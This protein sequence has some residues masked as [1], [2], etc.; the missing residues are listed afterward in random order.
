MRK[1]EGCWCQGGPLWPAET[2][3]FTYPPGAGSRVEGLVGRVPLNPTKICARGY[4]VP[5]SR[6]LSTVI[7]VLSAAQASGSPGQ[8]LSDADS[9]TLRAAYI[10]ELHAAVPA[11]I[12]FEA[13]SPSRRW[14]LCF[15]ERGFDVRPVDAS[16]TWGL[17]LTS[18]GFA[19]ALRTVA[20]P[21][22]VCADG[23]RVTYAWDGTL[24]EWYVNDER[25]LEHGYTVHERPPGSAEGSLTFTLAVR[26]ELRPIVDA[27]GRGVRFVND[28]ATRLTYRG[29]TVFDADGRE[30]DAGFELVGG[31]LRLCIDERGA[32]YPLTIDPVVQ[33][34]YLK[35]L[36]PDAGDWGAWTVAASGD[37]VVVG[38]PRES[39]SSSGVN[40]AVN[41]DLLSAGAAYVF[42]RVGGG[43]TTEA[44]L[45]ASNP[46]FTD[47]FGTTVAIDGDTIAVSA[48]KEDSAAVGVNGDESDNS[49]TRSGAVYVFVRSG[50]SWS[51]QA[52]IKASNTDM[53]DEFG[54]DLALSGDTL[55]VT[56][57]GEDSSATG[58]NGNAN[59]NTLPSWGQPMTYDAGAAYVFVRNGTTWSQEAYLK[60][61]NTEEHDGFGAAVALHGNTIVVGARDEDGTSPGVNG[62]QGNS[63]AN[64]P[65]PQ[66]YDAGAAY[67]FVRSGTTWTQEAYLK[68]SNPGIDDIF[69]FTVSLHGDTLAVAAA[70]EGSQ[71]TGVNGDQT[72]DSANESGAVYIFERTGTTWVQEAY[73]KASNTGSGDYFGSSVSLW[74]DALAVG[75]EHEDSNATGIDGD[76]LNDDSD[77]AGA[78]YL[79]RRSGGAWMQDA[80]LKASNTSPT[81]VAFWG[82]R[83]GRDVSLS[84]NLLVVGAPHEASA[85]SGV[86]GDQSD[87][88]AFQAG[89]AYAFYVQGGESGTFCTSSPNSTGRRAELSTA[90]SA[91]LAQNDLALLVDGGVPGQPGFFYFGSGQTDQPFGDGYLCVAGSGARLFPFIVMNTQGA[92]LLDLDLTSAPLVGLLA[93]GTWNFQFCYRDP[94]AAATG[95]NLSDGLSI[96][97]TP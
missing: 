91:S 29:L 65:N 36:A 60:A 26:G 31:A 11:R 78:V 53:W 90:G 87:D 7:L 70:L 24:E 6:T 69:G 13:Q 93:P 73:L 5:M 17:E 96:F 88:S 51:Q 54:L 23:G 12:G 14:S 48:V 58:I 94:A 8:E 44:Y 62:N 82:D 19:G 86:N 97:F 47:L 76:Q 4:T 77:N 25:G 38:F 66:D 22:D 32:R 80:Y 21:D 9:A 34:A 55:V 81:L 52:Y 20:I 33:Q 59:D 2:L 43:W 56:S 92:A 1:S 75:A 63:T 18:Y 37:T 15:D 16:W 30:F 68:S 61:S 64:W 41:N 40:G 39:G 89:A 42:R 83:F 28:A 71:A 72:D 85:S 50:T 84:G 74:G 95:F 3:C 67:V 10:A 46:E 79:F 57:T 27:D 45:K 49:A 35:A